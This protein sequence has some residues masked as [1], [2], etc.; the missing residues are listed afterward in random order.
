MQ[1]MQGTRSSAPTELYA[2]NLYLPDTRFCLLSTEL[3]VESNSSS[4]FH[5]LLRNSLCRLQFMLLKNLAT[6]C[7][8]ALVLKCRKMTEFRI[9]FQNKIVT[10]PIFSESIFPFVLPIKL[11]K[12]L[13]LK[14]K[15]TGS[16][17]K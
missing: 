10:C 15:V 9:L 2:L 8:V 17:S 3:M 5:L 11:K 4:T 14:K 7:I 6:I 16:T 12:P 13:K 1:L